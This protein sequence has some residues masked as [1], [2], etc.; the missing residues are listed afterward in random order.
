MT[1]NDH[2]R[3]F[4]HVDKRMADMPIKLKAPMQMKNFLIS[5]DVQKN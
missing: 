3:S 4:D 2:M 1:L 5:E